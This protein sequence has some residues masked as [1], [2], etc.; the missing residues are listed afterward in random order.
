MKM[1]KTTDNA[2]GAYTFSKYA[3][4]VRV[5]TITETLENITGAKAS[6]LHGYKSATLEKV[7]KLLPL[8]K[9]VTLV[10]GGYVTNVTTR[11]NGK[12]TVRIVYLTY[13]TRKNER[14]YFAFVFGGIVDAMKGFERCG[15]FDRYNATLFARMK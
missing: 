12:N 11:R 1:T 2:K 8:L 15:Q 5:E 6:T 9:N 3:Q 14:I 10:N 7:F 13:T 4:Q